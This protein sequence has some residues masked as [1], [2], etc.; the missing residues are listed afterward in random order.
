[1]LTRNRADLRRG[2]LGDGPPGTVRRPDADPVAGGDARRQQAQGE[3]VDV[4][5]Q[6]RVGPAAAGGDVQQSVAVRE[7]V[8]RLSKFFPIVSPSSEMSDT[9][10]V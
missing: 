2:V 10:D 4:G 5:L 8:D 3:R 6:L 9:S 7:A 1:M